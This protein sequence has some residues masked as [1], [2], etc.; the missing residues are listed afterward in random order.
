MTRQPVSRID[1]D[2]GSIPAI[3]G[4]PATVTPQPP[5]NTNA[6]QDS[7]AETY[8]AQNISLLR[9]LPPIPVRVVNSLDPTG[10]LFQWLN[11]LTKRVGGPTGTNAIFDDS[12]LLESND[13]DRASTLQRQLEE[14]QHMGSSSKENRTQ[15]QLEEFHLFQNEGSRHDVTMTGRTTMDYLKWNRNANVP[16]MDGVTY[17]EAAEHTISTVLDAAAG[18]TLEHGQELHVRV[19]NKTGTT[20]PN[21]SIVYAYGVLGNRPT[22]A[23][24]IAND[25]IKCK[26]IAIA[27]QDIL[28]NQEGFCT[29]FGVV[30]DVNTFGLPDAATL[31][32]SETVPGAW[33]TTVPSSPNFT[34]NLGI[35]L[36]STVNGSIYFR[37]YQPIACD[38][39]L[40]V[41]G[42]NQVP[43]T[44]KAVKDY[45]A[46]IATAQTITG[47]KKFGTDTNYSTFEADGTLVFA[48]DATVFDDINLSLSTGKLTGVG[49]PTWAA[50]VGNLYAYKFAVNDV[51][52]MPS[53]ELLHDWKEGSAIE[54]HVHWATNGLNDATLRGVKWEIEYT[55]ANMQSKGGTV[56]FATGTLTQSTDTTIAS[57][58]AGLTH[59]YSSIGTITM[60]GFRIGACFMARLKRITATGTAPANDPFAIH[61][62]VHYEKDTCGSRSQSAK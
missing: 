24:A 5:G 13:C 57:G 39:T 14:L 11:A 52:L 37:P 56:V 3:N 32:L 22:V 30:R 55:L 45:A 4:D 7:M 50:F 10:A 19:V 20:I 49:D 26:G 54:I 62:G 46:S 35:A 53:I 2:W 29:R 27:T 9:T 36:N 18:V 42:T 16:N 12:F 41:P 44:Q 34:V 31:Y 8:Q 23:L 25:Y 17:W 33:Q 47:A 28:N 21:G 59:K 51:I 61:V 15:S 60:T 58:E 40:A 43:L 6:T 1:T 38:N 48:G